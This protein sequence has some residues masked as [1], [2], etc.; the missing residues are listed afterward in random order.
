M[1]RKVTETKK[2][3]YTTFAKT[4]IL[5]IWESLVQSKEIRREI[6]LEWAVL[7]IFSIV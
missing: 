5:N 1:K 6:C 3:L 2:S 4:F 7:D